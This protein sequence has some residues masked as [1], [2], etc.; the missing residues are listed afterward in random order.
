MADTEI[1]KVT[2]YFGKISVGAMKLTAPLAVGDT[3][4]VKTHSGEFTQKVDSIQIDK[5]AVP[6]AAAGAEIGIKVAQ[7]VKEGDIVYKVS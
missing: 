2:H 1:G 4:K 5:N 7:P 6:A 3:I